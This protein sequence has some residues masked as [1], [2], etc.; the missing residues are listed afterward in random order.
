[1]SA[2][3]RALLYT[4][5]AFS[6]IYFITILVAC[7]AVAMERRPRWADIPGQFLGN[8]SVHTFQ[9]QRIDAQ[10]WRYCW[11]WCVPAWSVPR[12]YKDNNWG[13]QVSSVRESVRRGL[14][15]EAEE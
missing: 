13:D 9:Q 7:R 8:G 6:Q 12:S 3:N 4:D 5:T 14:E 11:K 15:P 10:Q 1:M 2:G